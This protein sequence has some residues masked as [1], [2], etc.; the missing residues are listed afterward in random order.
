MNG[1]GTNSGACY[2]WFACTGL[3]TPNEKNF[4]P[5]TLPV[6]L[7]MRRVATRLRPRTRK[8]ISRKD[9]FRPNRS[10]VK[11]ADQAIDEKRLTIN[12]FRPQRSERLPTIG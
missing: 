1:M 4:L 8:P 5:Q 3:F 12:P 10:E 11:P 6:Y 9:Q 7:A 2:P